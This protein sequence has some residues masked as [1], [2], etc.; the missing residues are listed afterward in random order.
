[1]VAARSSTSRECG[2][3]DPVWE[4]IGPSILLGFEL[5]GSAPGSPGVYGLHGCVRWPIE[6]GRFRML[7]FDVTID[8]RPGP[9]EATMSRTAVIVV[10]MQNDF[11][12]VGHVR[13]RRDGSCSRPERSQ[14]GA[15]LAMGS[16]SLR[17]CWRNRKAADATPVTA[18]TVPPATNGP[19]AERDS[20]AT[21][22]IPST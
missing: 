12:T 20:T 19:R 13:T 5:A 21:K 16:P 10:D 9:V 7:I 11:A 8:A 2:S 18:T 17:C 15:I 1:M 22:S 3:P 6:Y 4:V 14:F